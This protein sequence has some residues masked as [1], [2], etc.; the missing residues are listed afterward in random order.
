MI[1][2]RFNRVARVFGGD[3]MAA[4]QS[5]R[6][7]VFGI[8]GVGGW[9][10]EALARSGVGT[11]TIVDADSVAESNINRQPMAFDSTIGKPKVDVMKRRLLDINP[12]V[13]VTAI[14]RRFTI[15]NADDFDIG[16]YDYVIDAIDS[17][18]DK[19]SLIVTATATPGV[20]L[21]SSMGAALKTDP[22][23]VEVAEFSKV[24]GCRL[25]AALR[26]RF[27]RTGI[28]PRRK[29]RCVYSEESRRNVMDV[30]D[31]TSDA[32]TFGHVVT[33]GALVTVTATF[34]MTLASLVLND[35]ARKIPN[36]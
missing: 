34:G 24:K 5:S 35:I 22:T 8:G 6:V 33:N 7:I 17:L 21:F 13:K 15:D 19:A 32:M 1:P 2:Q 36:S 25:A 3:V 14:E 20:R 11:I 26:Q 23:R 12:D 28:Y 18:A 10:A 16:E 27:K 31:D 9:T 30:E 4:I 29:F